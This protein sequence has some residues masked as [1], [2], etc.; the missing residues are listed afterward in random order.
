[1]INTFQRYENKY[2]LNESAFHNLTARLT[3]Y[4]EPD[5]NCSD[6]RSY[7]IYNLYYDTEND[8][9]IRRSLTKPYYKE[10]LRLRSYRVPQSYSDLVFLELKKKIG[11]VVC[12]RRAEMTLSEAY[13]F[14]AAGK[15]PSAADYLNRQVISEIEYFLYCN[16][17]R[18]KVAINYERMAFLGRDDRGFRITFDTN[19][20]TRR[21]NLG[22]EKGPGGRN[23]LFD[24]QYLMEIKISGAIPLWLSQALSE[25]EVYSTSYSKYGAEYKRYLREKSLR[26]LDIAR[27]TVFQPLTQETAWCVNL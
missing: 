7:N 8:D 3:R 27:N 19:I 10:K 2:L 20:K 17:V 5:Q 25:N 9:I 11:G 22:L 26:V 4:M 13:H 12:K 6:D 21:H 24:R 15:A 18:P 1:M 16:Q 14:I 23:L